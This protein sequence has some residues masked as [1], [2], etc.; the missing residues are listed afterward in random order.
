[1]ARTSKII[2]VKVDILFLLEYFQLVTI[3][4]VSCGFFVYD[5]YYVEVVPLYPHCLE[6]F[7]QKSC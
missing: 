5:F 1:M 2:V 4:N 7:Y 6:N 3:E